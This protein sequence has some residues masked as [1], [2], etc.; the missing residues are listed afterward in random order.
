MRTRFELPAA[1]FV[2][3]LSALTASA[4]DIV[5]SVRDEAGKPLADAV[6]IAVPEVPVKP[7][8]PRREVIVQESK[9]FKPFVKAVLVGTAVEFPN[10][11]DVQHHVYSFSPARTFELKAYAGTP[12]QP[13]VFDKPGAVALGCNIHDWMLAYVYVSESPYFGTSGSDGTAR[14]TALPPGRYA[15][16]IWHPRLAVPESATTQAVTLSG[17]EVTEVAWT[18]KL[19]HDS[20]IRR[21]PTQAGGSYR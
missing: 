2:L 7:P 10:R 12:P 14:L 13:I 8:A 4:H 15:V 21:A 3:A 19:K 17:D 16:R 6:A 18:L 5:V 20:R 1:L 11:D 9:E